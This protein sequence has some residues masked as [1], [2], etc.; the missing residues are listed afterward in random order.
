MRPT[1]TYFSDVLCIWAY[2]SQIRLDQLAAEYSDRIV[3][4]EKFCSVYPDARTKTANT[5]DKKGG[6]PAL[7]EMYQ[8]I[9]KKYPHISVHPDVW[10]KTQPRSSSS[11]HQFL[12]A[13]QLLDA[14]APF[15]EL[16]STDAIRQFRSAFF[17]DARDVSDWN[18]QCEIAEELGLDVGKIE[19]KIYSAEAAA[20]L[21]A[22]L[23]QAKLLHI[24]GSPTFVM[25]EGRQILFGNVGYKLVEANVEELFRETTG[26]FASWC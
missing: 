1:V 12:K 17:A 6:Y 8:N 25:N 24:I 21:D 18:V 23:K 20:S 4:E 5:W 19:A 22:D 13:I 16:A 9:V 3:I 7:N 11:V 10:T 2:V 15:A 14:D 26:D